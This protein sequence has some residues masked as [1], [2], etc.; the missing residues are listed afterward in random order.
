[1]KSIALTAASFLVLTSAIAGGI[2]K[3]PLPAQPV[4]D[5]HLG[6]VRDKPKYNTD[7]DG[8][9]L[10]FGYFEFKSDNLNRYVDTLGSTHNGNFANN[11][12]G[13]SLDNISNN[14]KHLDM[15]SGIAWILPQT[16]GIGTGDSVQL[17][18]GGWHWTTSFLGYDFIDGE[19]VTLALAPAFAWGNL[20]MRRMDNGQKTKYTNPFV[21][22][23]GRAEFRLTFGNF[24]IGGRATYRYDITYA[25]WKRKANMMP[26]L[27]EYKNHGLAYFGYIG[28]IF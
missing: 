13:I 4:P 2:K 19:T 18:L 9:A 28:L 21:A 26:V 3:Y 5:L 22:P 12:M 15:I 17:R 25:L 24:M 7:R 16:V 11:Y 10:S 1:M 8:R 6:M 23:G 14:G 27:P 20:K